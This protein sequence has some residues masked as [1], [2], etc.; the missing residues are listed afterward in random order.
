MT[1]ALPLTMLHME[2]NIDVTIPIFSWT[3]IFIAET[4]KKSV[5]NKNLN[6]FSQPLIFCLKN[7]L[8][9]SLL[10]LEGIFRRFS[11]KFSQTE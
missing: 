10:L 3:K 4:S 9:L 6:I 5:T 11:F 1:E 7:K 2:S 8:Y